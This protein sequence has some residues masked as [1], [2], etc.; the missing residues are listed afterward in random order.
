ML[1][2]YLTLDLCKSQGCRIIAF[3][4]FNLPF[5]DNM[6]NWVHSHVL[7]GHLSFLF[8][9]WH[10]HIFCPFFHWVVYLFSFWFVEAFYK[11][12]ILSFCQFYALQISS[13][14]LFLVFL[15]C[16]WCLW[17]NRC[18]LLNEFKLI[19]F[20][21]FMVRPFLCHLKRKTFA[22]LRL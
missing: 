17:M 1:W 5:S 13:Q 4:C 21:F 2:Y 8:C 22:N 10:F 11:F 20:F 7:I 3:Y 9:E 14:N 16:L 19:H 15:P 6:S 18:S 12:W